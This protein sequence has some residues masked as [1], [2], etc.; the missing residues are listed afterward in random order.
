MICFAISHSENSVSA[1]ELLRVAVELIEAAKGELEFVLVDGGIA[2]KSAVD[3]LNIGQNEKEKIYLT[4]KA[5]FTHMMRLPFS[6]GG[7]YR[8]GKGS[9]VRGL[10]KRKVKSKQLRQVREVD[11]C[12]QC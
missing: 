11:C 12:M 9:I 3:E 1:L 5:C 4:L 2:L 8:G 10:I 6:R 7:G